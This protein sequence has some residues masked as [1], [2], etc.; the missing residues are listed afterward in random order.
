[1][2]QSQ[3]ALARD[4]QRDAKADLDR[5]VELH[6]Q[7]VNLL[8]AAKLSDAVSV[9][10]GANPETSAELVHPVFPCMHSK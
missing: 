9:D 10:E 2:I 3:T 7:R 1:M 5:L 4:R 8:S 6:S